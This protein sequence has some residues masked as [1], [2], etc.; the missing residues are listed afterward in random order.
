MIDTPRLELFLI[1]VKEPGF[2]ATNAVVVNE[3]HD[4]LS[5][6]VVMRV[7]PGC[8][9]VRV[10]ARHRMSSDIVDLLPIDEYASAVIERFEVVRA[11]PYMNFF[12]F[13]LNVI[14]I[15]TH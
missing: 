13:V 6:R 14:D 15:C 11:A 5:F 12:G 2:R 1:A 10:V 3:R 9:S 8:D 4:V 7:V